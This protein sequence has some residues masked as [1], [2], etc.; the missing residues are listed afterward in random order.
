MVGSQ[1]AIF[2]MCVYLNGGGGGWGH[3]MRYS[4]YVCIYMVVGGGWGHSMGAYGIASNNSQ[5]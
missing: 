1:Y 2:Q 3:N 5:D 4:E